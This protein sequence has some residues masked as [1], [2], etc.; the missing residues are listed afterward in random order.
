MSL[1]SKEEK[2][3]NIAKACVKARKIDVQARREINSL[4]LKAGV[5]APYIY[6]LIKG[7]Y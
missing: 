6:K 5:T 3:D 7:H 1:T 2:A 4:A